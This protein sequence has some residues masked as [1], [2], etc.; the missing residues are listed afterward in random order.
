[1]K[2]PV[3]F[4]LVWMVAF[5]PLLWR[6][7]C[8]GESGIT[9]DKA[10]ADRYFVSDSEAQPEPELFQQTVE[11]EIPGQAEFTVDFGM[12]DLGAV[13]HRYLFIHNS[14]NIQLVAQP[15]EWSAPDTAFSVACLQQGIFVDGCPS[16]ATAQP[17]D[18]LVLRFSFSPAELGQRHAELTMSTNAD[19]FPTW[20]I[21]LQGQGVTPEIQVC[22]SDCVG[23][24]ESAAC[25][26]AESICNDEVDNLVVDFG[27]TTPDQPLGREVVIRNIGDQQLQVTDASLQGNHSVYFAVQQAEG[28]IPGVVDPGGQ[29]RIVV[30]YQPVAGGEHQA[31]LQIISNDQNEREIAIELRGRALAPRVCPEPLAV[32]FGSVEVGTS[33]QKGFT[34]TNC[35]LLDLTIDR[36][37]L[38]QSSSPDFSLV[39][40]PAM[41]ITLAP[42]EQLQVTVE[43]T[44]GE[45]GSDS[46]EVEIYSNDPTSD[47]NGLTGRISLAG[48]GTVRECQ[49][50]P[51]PFALA[52]G[53]VV[54]GTT[55]TLVLT[56]SNQGNDS[57]R[58]DGVEI[59]ENSPDG[60]FSI[61]SAPAAGTTFDPGD[62]VMPEI[63][64]QYAPVNLGVDRGR[65]KVTGNDLDGPEIFVDVTGEGVETAE[66]D[67][68]V[69]PA[70]LQFGTVKLNTTKSQVISL[71]NQGN[72]PCNVTEPEFIPSTLFPSDFV[73]TRGPAGPFTLE[74]KGRPGDR[75]EIE[76]TFAPTK[77]DLHAGRIWFHTDDDPDILAGDGTCFKPGVP[78]Q[79][80][81]A[82]DA[83]INLSGFSAESDIEVVPGE[84]DFGVVTV[85][86]NSP[87]LAV[88]VYNLGTIALNITSIHLEDPADPNFEI[89]SAPMTPYNLAGGSSMEI[90]LRYHPQ[91]A[92][93]HRN[94]L[95]IESDASNVQLLAV[96]IFGRGTTDS[97]QTDIFHQPTQVKSDVL[98]VVD[99]S[100]S[101]GWVQAELANNFSSFINWAQTLEVDFHIG[102]IAT[103]VNDPET[104]I[105]DPPRDVFPGVL[106][107]TDSSPKIITNQTPNISDAFAKNVKLGT[108]CSDEQEAG[109]Q[110]AWMALSEPLVDDPSANQGFLREDA[111]LYIICVSDEQDQSKGN[112]D[113][114]IDFF[115][116]IKGPR[117]TDMMKVSAIVIP[118]P[119]PTGCGGSSS[120]P[121]T[122]YIE[123]AN[124]TGGIFEPLCTSDWAAALS[125]LGIDAFAAVREFPLSRPADQSTITVSVNGSTVPKA[126]CND[127][128]ACSDGWVYYPDTNSVCFG[129][130]YVP[131]KGDTI[132][133]SYTAA[134]L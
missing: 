114:Y 84:L 37:E 1:M 40:L 109:L 95:Y 22:I 100:G 4:Y 129:S 51:I 87:E 90:R 62:V 38:S 67:L 5:L 63:V 55:D 94:T 125:N 120:T 126:S 116:S 75:E 24:Q 18:D 80:P 124:Q 105:G 17:G 89:T 20:H 119:P 77:L 6:C 52:F 93:P 82:G 65:I 14:G 131:E 107:K 104:D 79:P 72:A 91:D 132:E 108:C 117:N 73:I 25:T 96:P 112:P 15:P 101:M 115:K 27:D 2:T 54:Q 133:I 26:S 111:K 36:V 122:R 130:D 134:C 34:V 68:V 97:S 47:E 46:G 86:C 30:R 44:P 85:G 69:Q 57:C 74:R 88:R 21:V 9:Q 42:A 113:F 81:Q 127:C 128:D 7:D 12:V 70:S 61:V 43:Y 121:G 110:A 31:R 59:V 53:G 13:E 99:N 49:I 123:V 33:M 45:R 10:L 35:G 58:F 50:Q 32:D 11:G 19:D 76:V 39:Q 41:P 83:C 78:P 103:E 64:V 71:V 8:Q 16:A 106:V 48:S 66:C 23:G 118:D 28:Q 92:T 29:A 56:L 102:V 98:F 60:E 3:R